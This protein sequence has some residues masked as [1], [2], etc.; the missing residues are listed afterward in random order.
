MQSC[1]DENVFHTW[2][3]ARRLS[4]FCILTQCFTFDIEIVQRIS[5]LLLLPIWL[6]IHRWLSARWHSFTVWRQTC[7]F[8]ALLNAFGCVKTTKFQ[9]KNEKFT[10]KIK[11][12][13][14]TCSVE[15]TATCYCFWP[16]YHQLLLLFVPDFDLSFMNCTCTCFLKPEPAFCLPRKIYFCTHAF[17]IRQ[18]A[19]TGASLLGKGMHS[20]RQVCFL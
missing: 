20:Y 14:S 18:K 9:K 10:E 13:K 7:S 1:H 19:G 5:L 8:W 15:K 3:L 12:K 4:S 2:S 16:A 17:T 11:F 6:N